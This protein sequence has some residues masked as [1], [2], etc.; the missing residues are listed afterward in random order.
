M[1]IPAHFREPDERSAKEFIR[2]NGFGIFVTADGNIPTATHVPMELKETPEGASY[3]QFHISYGNGQWRNIS[4]GR[5]AMAIFHGPH[6][7]VS[8]S[9]Y[10]EVNVPTWNYITAHVYGHARIISDNAEV[11]QI[12]KSLVDKHEESEKQPFTIESLP[13]ERL[14]R[15]M[16]GIVAIRMDIDRIEASFKLSQNRTE[17][18]RRA[19]IAELSKRESEGDREIAR[20]MSERCPGHHGAS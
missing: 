15:L 10:E 11:H 2:N 12:L 17:R 7:H 18:D 4:P 14:S 9:W 8:S 16:K 20:V 5:P 6:A 3:L 13:E 19:I 1:Y